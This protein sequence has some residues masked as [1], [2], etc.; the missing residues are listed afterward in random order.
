MGFPK[1]PMTT[2]IKIHAK[3]SPSSS[4][5]WTICHG[6]YQR[7]QALGLR[8]RESSLAADSGTTMHDI[9]EHI[10]KDGTDQYA[11]LRRGTKARVDEDGVVLYAPANSSFAKDY[12]IAVDDDLVDG[13]LTYADFVRK[14]VMGGGKLLVEQRLSISHIT[15]EQGAK[16]TSDTVILFPDEICIVDLKG[17]YDRVFASYPF[18]GDYFK[19]GPKEQQLKALFKPDDIRFPN[20]QLVMY[21]SAALNAYP[22]PYKRVRIIIVQPRLDHIDEHVMSMEDFNEWVQWISEQST[23]CEQPNP[24]VVP[25]VKQCQYCAVFPCQEANNLALQTAVDDFEDKPKAPDRSRL[26]ELKRLVPFVRMW[27]DAVDSRV[28]AELTTGNPVDGFKLVQGDQ[29]D[30]QWSSEPLAELELMGMGLSDS[31][32]LTRKLVG[33]AAIEKM[34]LRKRKT[35]N[36]KLTLDQWEQLQTL[37]TRAPGGPKVVPDTDPRPALVVDPTSDFTFEGDTPGDSASFFD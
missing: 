12:P 19:Y 37:I 28:Q 2:Q 23:A 8:A 20:P 13:A 21:A 26:G 36:K 1:K 6:A 7:E 35:P 15:G 18:R 33:P 11:E 30:R 24:R 4:I 25:G 32:F 5:R 29:G 22:G 17:G 27:C 3:R 31:D 9:G 34:V 10:L 14:L 16:G